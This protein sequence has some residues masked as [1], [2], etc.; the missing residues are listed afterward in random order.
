MLVTIRW[1]RRS[2][3]FA[4]EWY[5]AMVEME[6]DALRILTLLFYVGDAGNFVS[7]CWHSSGRDRGRYHQGVLVIYFGSAASWRP[8]L[9]EGPHQGF[10]HH[11]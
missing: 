10:V 9:V 6:D 1:R 8:C 2:S 7:G 5:L 3:L 4:A 11:S